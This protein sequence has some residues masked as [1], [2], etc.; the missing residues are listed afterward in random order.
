MEMIQSVAMDEG[1]ADYF[2]CSLAQPQGAPVGE[3]GD[4]VA[5]AGHFLWIVG[6]RCIRPKNADLRSVIDMEVGNLRA[7]CGCLQ[8]S[9][10][11]GQGPTRSLEDFFYQWGTIWA[12]FLWKLRDEIGRE[13]AGY[14]HRTQH[15]IL[16]SLVRFSCRRLCVDPG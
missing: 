6:P 15:P 3:F 10:G 9:D 5:R 12:S 4:I 14:A 13:A 8:P 2:A 11:A 1:L 16:E 7:L